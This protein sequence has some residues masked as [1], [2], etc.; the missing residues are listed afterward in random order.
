MKKINDRLKVDF[1][2]LMGSNTK[3]NIYKG[4]F[5]QKQVK[6]P[7]DVMVKIITKEQITEEPWREDSIR[8]ELQI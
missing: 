4:W 1:D 2:T 3:Y 6:R 7:I 8:N 5:T